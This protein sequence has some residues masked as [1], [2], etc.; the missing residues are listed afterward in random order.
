MPK[1]A[2]FYG[3]VS[4]YGSMDFI[5][6]INASLEDDEEAEITIR[7]NTP[8]GE[9]EYGWGMCAKINELANKKVK[10]DGK[11]YSFGTF[12]LCYVDDSE[13]V[14]NA[15]FMVHRAAYTEWFEN[16]EYFNDGLKENLA[17]I[18]KS[19]EQA[20]RN[21]I[22]VEAFENLKQ[23]KSKGITVKSIFSMDSRVDVFFNA[24]DAKA[25][26]LINRIVQLTPSKKAELDSKFAVVTAKYIGE[27]QT[28]IKFK[29]DKNSHEE[30]EQEVPEKKLT[31]MTAEKLKSDFPEV[32]AAIKAEGVA[33]EKDRVEGIMV[34]VEIDPAA[35]KLAV[36]SDKP[37][38]S[39]QMA[40]LTLKSVS[41]ETLAKIEKDSAKE[42]ATGEVKQEKP[43]TEAEKK[44][45]DFEK[46][47]LAELKK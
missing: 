4:G 2:L 38:S 27:D 36:E 16:S 9:P 28:R 46:E 41:K 42:V 15:Q 13:A 24:K 25:I 40:E 17:S 47:V 11:A 35:C 39:K 18:N 44:L 43:K 6:Q 19:L 21:K 37:L 8:G 10:V 31:K 34:F 29:A 30:T 20:F 33:A 1:E 3:P 45:A 32:Y 7:V 12:A 26:K 22:D 5:Q 23:C 14:D